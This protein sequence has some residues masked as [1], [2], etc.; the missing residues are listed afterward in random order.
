MVRKIGIVSLS[1]GLLGEPF[2]RHEEE[3]GLCRLRDRGLEVSFLPHARAGLDFIRAHPEA[4]AADLLQ[5]LRDPEIDMILCAIGG[6]DSYRLLPWLFG[7]G[8]LAAAAGAAAGKIFLGFSD[9][10]VG[11]LMLHK[12]GLRSF[13]GQ[14]FLPDVCEPGPEM[15][16][17]TR[18]CFDELCA[19]GGI[20][21]VRPS[22]LRYASRT[23]WSPAALGS[24]LPA[25]PGTGFE[26]LQGP[27]RFSG[28]IL[29]GCLDTLHD[30]FDPTRY[31]DMP[32]LCRRYGLFPP[33]EDWRGRILLLETSEERMSPAKYRRALGYLRDAG[34]FDAVSGI[35]V[36]RPVDGAFDREYR[37]ALTELVRRP[38]LP[39]VWGL[40][41]GHA[42]PRCIL[43]FGVEARVDAAAQVIRFPPDP[44]PTPL[45]SPDPAG[46]PG[47]SP[48]P[49]DPALPFS[50]QP[51]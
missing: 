33:P 10:T 26:L 32:E 12:V 24:E 37:A 11:H 48:T 35:L 29:G 21:E 25:C 15:L 9:T 39:I 44:A 30:V 51:C 13:Y 41:V 7:H 5:A 31:A 8:E 22:P 20:R 43:P 3:L 23:D 16:P 36:G 45:A 27:P 28:Q 47:S 18:R 40:D 14:A 34:V 1:R 2:V 19:T 4:R 46:A 42:L 6:D 17:Y 38:A 49:P 50:P